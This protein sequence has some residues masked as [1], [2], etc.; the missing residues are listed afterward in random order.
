MPSKTHSVPGKLTSYEAE[1]VLHEKGYV[2]GISNPG[3]TLRANQEHAEDRVIVIWQFLDEKGR[4]TGEWKL[5]KNWEGGL[6]SKN[7]FESDMDYLQRVMNS[8][9]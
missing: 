1:Q 3:K 9:E 7:E 8:F 4:L 5:S 6:I 2:G